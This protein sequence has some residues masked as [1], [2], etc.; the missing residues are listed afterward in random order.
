MTCQYEKLRKMDQR[1]G[2][3]VEMF[4]LYALAYRS[5][6]WLT[7][8]AGCRARMD[9][10]A[11]HLIPAFDLS[12]VPSLFQRDLKFRQKALLYGIELERQGHSCNLLG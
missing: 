9:Q 7:F 12:Y 3:C 1:L 5:Q 10:F 4:T 6:D 8:S 11:Q 2:R